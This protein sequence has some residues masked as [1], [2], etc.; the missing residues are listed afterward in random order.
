MKTILFLILAMAVAA[1]SPAEARRRSLGVHAPRIRT[2]RIHT[3]R[4]RTPRA[5][6]K[7]SRSIRITRA[8]GTVLT[9]T[10]DSLGTHLAGP[11]G[12]RVDCKR[13]IGAADI[14]VSCR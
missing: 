14:E 12:R 1:G 5:S 8:D 2:A 9:G 7:A 4:L 6:R 13:G 10:R 11:D 3:P